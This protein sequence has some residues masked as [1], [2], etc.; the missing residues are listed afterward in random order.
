MG[1]LSRLA[2]ALVVWLP[3]VA[4]NAWA[5]QTLWNWYIPQ[6]LD[7]S[8]IEFPEAVGIALVSTYL[9]HRWPT[10]NYDT[11]KEYWEAFAESLLGAVLKPLFGVGAGWVY[12]WVWPL[13]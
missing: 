7:L 12:L 3:L 8:K 4:L 10:G 2:I 13:G 6:I 5:V 1:I 9:T 11:E